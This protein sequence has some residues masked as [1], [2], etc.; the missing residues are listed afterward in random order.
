M[1]YLVKAYEINRMFPVEVECID[2]GCSNNSFGDCLNHNMKCLIEK[3][4]DK[5]EKEKD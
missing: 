4:R 5:D 2:F 3:Q 1:I